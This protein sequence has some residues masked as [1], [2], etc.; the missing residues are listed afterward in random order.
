MQSAMPRDAG[1]AML[2]RITEPAR[3]LGQEK[4]DPT[5][6]ARG[7]MLGRGQWPIRANI[8]VSAFPEAEW[9]EAIRDLYTSE[10]CKD[11]GSSRSDLAVGTLVRG[12]KER[13]LLTVRLC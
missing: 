11:P 4:R 9:S 10:M 8:E 6:T 2:I 1:T 5:S 12:R 7:E 3:R 13:F